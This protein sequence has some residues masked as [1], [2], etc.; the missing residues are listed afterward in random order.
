MS[1]SLLEWILGST[2]KTTESKIKEALCNEEGRINVSEYVFG[3]RVAFEQS[4]LLNFL[5]RHEERHAK[6]DNSH[7]LI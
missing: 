5:G 7:D 3:L 2:H 1:C 4:L 6:L